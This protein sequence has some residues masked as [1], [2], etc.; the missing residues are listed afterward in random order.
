MPM[1]TAA[2]SE[3][4]SAMIA[5]PWK[6][7]M[8]NHITMKPFQK[9]AKAAVKRCTG[10]NQRHVTSRRPGSWLTLN[11]SGNGSAA[12]G[13]FVK[14]SIRASSAAARVRRSITSPQA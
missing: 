13:G 5:S 9:R 1:P 6:M 2:C 4:N 3:P 12:G 14:A 7:A 11:F 8:P 10:E